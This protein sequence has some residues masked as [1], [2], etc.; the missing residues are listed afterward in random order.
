MYNKPNGDNM[1]RTKIEYLHY[2]WNPIVGCNGLGCA[3]REKCWAMGQAKRQKHRCDLCYQFVPHVH[4][5]RFEQPLK[6]KKPSRIGTVFMG[7]FFSKDVSEWVRQNLYLI[8]EK[9]D[10]HTFIIFTKQPQNIVEPLPKNVWLA[11]SIN[12]K[13]D[14]WRLQQLKS[15]DVSVKIVSFEP[16]YEAIDCN[17]EGIDWIIIGAQTRPNLQPKFEWVKSLMDQADSSGCRVF[18][19]DNLEEWQWYKCKEYPKVTS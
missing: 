8:M 1:N 7:E 19:K 4:W 14:L 10:W 15:Y 5:N 17:L 6:V 13:N 12:R 16:L 11:V 9:A 3:V 2:T 18:L